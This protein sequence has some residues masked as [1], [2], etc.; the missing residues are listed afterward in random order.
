MLELEKFNNSSIHS[1]TA[2]SVDEA[3]T[4]ITNALQATDE[5]TIEA[6]LQPDEADQEGPARILTLSGDPSNRNIMLGQGMWSGNDLDKYSLRLRTNDSSTSDN[7]SPETLS[8]ANV[9]S[10][11]LTH[12]VFTFDTAGNATVYRNGVQSSSG[13][14]AG[15]LNNWDS[16]YPLMLGNETTLDRE[17]LGDLH[18]MAIYDKVLT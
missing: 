5:L 13:T 11:N 4:K 7:G 10:T 1:K 12:V 15:N 16:S 3:A 6:W 8:G 2:V 14:I 17:W 9:V 18:F